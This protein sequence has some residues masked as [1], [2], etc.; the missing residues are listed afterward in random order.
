MSL[1][2]SPPDPGIRPLVLVVDDDVSVCRALD[3]LFRSAGLDVETFASAGALLSYER[4]ARP[5][6]VVTDLH[7]PDLHGLDLLHVIRQQDPHLPVIVITGSAE[8]GVGSRALEWGATAFLS[9]PFDEEQL[10][11]E[12]R[13]ALRLIAEL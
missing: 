11:D 2:T 1:N 6:C 9:K 10:L 4:P 7:L 8:K 5:A 13:R 12:V 3:R